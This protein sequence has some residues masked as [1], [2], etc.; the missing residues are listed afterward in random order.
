[1][2]WTEKET[3]TCKLLSEIL[4]SNKA[5]ESNPSGLKA[6]A[7]LIKKLFEDKG[8]KVRAIETQRQLIAQSSSLKLERN[9]I[10][11]E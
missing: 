7:V 10:A 6:N 3:K 9:P 5:V 2:V 4:V 8:C 1:M 11:V